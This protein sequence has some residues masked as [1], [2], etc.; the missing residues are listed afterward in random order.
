M[1]KMHNPAH[2]GEVLRD[3]L[4]DMS[5][6]EVAEHLGVARATLSRLLN[7][8]Q[9]ISPE[10]DLRLARALGTTEG[11]WLTMQ[12]NY[13]IWEAKKHFRAKVKPFPR[14]AAA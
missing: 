5:V 7:G 9:G 12:A 8:S 6:T 13:D 4:G 14:H 2:P 10:M 11:M 1:S 3:A